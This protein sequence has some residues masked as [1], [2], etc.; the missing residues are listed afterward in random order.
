ML[1][2]ILVKSKLTDIC[3]TA[4]VFTPTCEPF[5]TPYLQDWATPPRIT[6][7]RYT[8]DLCD[9]GYRNRTA[10]PYTDTTTDQLINLCRRYVADTMSEKTL[11][12]WCRDHDGIIMVYVRH[13]DNTVCVYDQY[14]LCSRYP[15]NAY[16]PDGLFWQ[17]YRE[18]K[19]LLD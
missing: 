19:T 8:I 6:L 14:G 18:L 1:E 15:T 12:A 4:P 2:E 3:F 5:M 13:P 7:N 16:V 17:T 10:Y 9:T 11:W